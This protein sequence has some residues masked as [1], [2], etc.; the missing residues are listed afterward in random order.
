[1]LLALRHCPLVARVCVRVMCVCRSL[2][3]G[4]RSSV[5][6]R[7]THPATLRWY[8]NLNCAVPPPC[9]ASYKMVA[10]ATSRE[11]LSPPQ[12]RRALTGTKLVLRKGKSI[13]SDKVRDLP[14]G[15][16][17]MILEEML[18]DDG[19]VR[20]RIGVDSSPRGVAV[21]TVGW[22]TAVRDGESKLLGMDGSSPTGSSRSPTGDSMAARIAARR[23]RSA[24]SRRRSAT[25]RADFAASPPEQPAASEEAG[26]E[27]KVEK[28]KERPFMTEA[29]LLKMALDYR[30]KA[31]GQGGQDVSTMSSKLGH[32]LM[33]K[34]IKVND[35]IKEWDRNNDGDISKNEF[36]VNVR[37]LGLEVV[38]GKDLDKLY[39]ELDKSGDGTIDTAELKSA[40]LQLQNDAS[41]VV[42]RGQ[43][44]EKVASYAITAAEALES[45]AREA[46]AYEAASQELAHM[47]EN[48]SAESRLGALLTTRNVKIGDA[49]RKWDNDG[50][51]TI[52]MQEFSA[53]VTKLGFKIERPGEL[54]DVFRKLD[55]DGSGSLELDELKVA[56]KSLQDEA[57]NVV[58]DEK[59]KVASL[60]TVKKTAK[61]AQRAAFEVI[62]AADTEITSIELATLQA[63]RAALEK[64]AKARKVEDEKA[65][66][67]Q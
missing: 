18:L 38:D 2:A 51:G 4:A 14:A 66:N 56:L 5:A 58:K 16:P 44:A 3:C 60:A 26:K 43:L 61:A 22:V 24:D 12:I 42:E 36:R 21:H 8:S 65:A 10:A 54:D 67:K 31:D 33:R 28:K 9:A 45:C 63:K 40:L 47:K 46:A 64:E 39:D 62:D 19:V 30:A 32:I 55:D 7:N 29:E 50:D 37:K 17:I 59:A 41:V 34:N 20:A 23:R 27:V 15:S 49:M 52:S 57:V 25:S 13:E 1:M 6:D 11:A 48:R 35:L 53:E